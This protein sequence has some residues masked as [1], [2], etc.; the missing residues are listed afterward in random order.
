MSTTITLPLRPLPTPP[1]SSSLPLPSPPYEVVS[2]FSPMPHRYMLLPLS[3]DHNHNNAQIIRACRSRTHAI[4]RPVYIVRGSSGNIMG[5][6]VPHYVL[7]G[8]LWDM[9]KKEGEGADVSVLHGGENGRLHWEKEME[10]EME[11]IMMDLDEDS[12]EESGSGMSE[13][14]GLDPAPDPDRGFDSDSDPAV[15]PALEMRS[16]VNW[17]LIGNR[18]VFN[19]LAQYY[20][21]HS[22]GDVEEYTGSDTGSSM[23]EGSDSDSDSGGGCEL[24]YGFESE[25][26]NDMEDDYN[27][28]DESE[29]ESDSEPDIESGGAP[30]EPHSTVSG[31]SEARGL[32]SMMRL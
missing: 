31:T 30:L 27:Y 20:D 28:H 3:P 11:K 4:G 32:L 9:E 15:D 21:D 5:I 18:W 2:I 17:S 10:K 1:P 25:P 6:R 29:S 13:D 12:G 16:K 7:E 19:D 22:D 24:Y 23:S 8:V 26:E 14:E